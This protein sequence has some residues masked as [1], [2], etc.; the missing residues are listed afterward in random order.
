MKMM[1]AILF[2]LF[3]FAIV[4]FRFHSGIAVLQVTFT[5]KFFEKFLNIFFSQ[6]VLFHFV[7]SITFFLWLSTL[8]VI[9]KL[10]NRSSAYKYKIIKVKWLRIANESVLSLHKFAE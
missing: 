1:G 8:Q 4:A 7:I 10:L 9:N 5:F 2:T 3:Q 6:I